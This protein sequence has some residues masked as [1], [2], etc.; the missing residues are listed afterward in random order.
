MR[1]KVHVTDEILL[2][3]ENMFEPLLDADPA[4]AP[5]WQTFVEEWADDKDHEPPLYLALADV[6]RHL[7]GQ[8]K[9]GEIEKFD[10]VFG[11]VERWHVKGNSYV[12]QAATVGLLESLQNTNL[13]EGTK[14]EDFEGWLLPE[15][16]RWWDKLNR[17]W[18]DGELLTE[19]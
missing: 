3:R 16:K 6:A 2:T 17:F 4:F 10:A 5:L 18:S 19:G 1:H 13:H 14:P 12:R 7:I 15:S 11:V 9:T 8:L